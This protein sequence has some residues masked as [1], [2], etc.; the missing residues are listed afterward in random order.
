MFLQ[1]KKQ[2]QQKM[3]FDSPFKRKRGR[4]S[5]NDITPKH[6]GKPL[7]KK[8]RLSSST[9]V[10]IDKDTIKE[11]KIKIVFSA[12]WFPTDICTTIEQNFSKQSQATLSKLAERNQVPNDDKLVASLAKK[13]LEIGVKALITIL[14]EET[15]KD[16]LLQ[17]RSFKAKRD[18][19]QQF[20]EALHKHSVEGF[21]NHLNREMLLSITDALQYVEEG[22]SHVQL[23]DSL[24]EEV[25]LIGAK[26]VWDQMKK[27]DLFDIATSN[28]C[29]VNTGHTKKYLIYALLMEEFPHLEDAFKNHEKSTTV[30]TVSNAESSLKDMNHDD[31]MHYALALLGKEVSSGKHKKLH[32][33]SVI[34]HMGDVELDVSES[35]D[36]SAAFRIPLKSLK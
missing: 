30:S 13:A 15:M 21:F 14:P 31:Q 2:T 4:P 26:E 24:L 34:C 36:G 10:A 23:V 25:A 33:I 6:S 20:Y 22:A 28:K 17:V 35:A 29:K 1:P 12:S 11:S 8:P 5:K 16:A 9:D 7:R 27:E 18:V 3:D 32:V 19:K